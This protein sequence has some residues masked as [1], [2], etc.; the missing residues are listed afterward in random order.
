M[1]KGPFNIGSD[2]SVILDANDVQKSADQFMLERYRAFIPT[3]EVC[4]II[5]SSSAYQNKQLSGPHYVCD[6]FHLKTPVFNSDFSTLTQRTAIA[7][8]LGYSEDDELYNISLAKTASAVS[9]I[10]VELPLPL[11][12][13]STQVKRICTDVLMHC[14]QDAELEKS[15]KYHSECSISAGVLSGNHQQWSGSFINIGD[16]MIVILD[17]D[18]LK[19][20][21]ISPAMVKHRTKGNYSPVSVHEMSKSADILGLQADQIALNENDII[22]YM[23]DGIYSGFDLQVQNSQRTEESWDESFPVMKSIIIT[24]DAFDKA[25]AP[26]KAKEHVSASDVAFALLQEQ[27]RNFLG[28]F[29][30]IKELLQKLQVYTSKNRDLLALT[31]DKLLNF[32]QE[33]DPALKQAL[34]HY[35]HSSGQHDGVTFIP[36]KSL[37]CDLIHVLS[38]QEYG[39]CSTLSV[40]KVPNLK[41][42]LIKSYLDSKNPFVLQTITKLI[43]P[44]ECRTI[45]EG[46]SGD[47]HSTQGL[48]S[49]GV[50]IKNLITCQQFSPASLQELTTTLL[51]AYTGKGHGF[52]DKFTYQLGAALPYFSLAGSS[53]EIL[54]KPSTNNRKDNELKP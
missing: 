39:D 50:L 51:A 44:T 28:E 4:T 12:I 54:P 32:L 49:E 13:D 26:L 9:N 52:W 18:T 33:H 10:F 5:G 22:I 19:P 46:M 14:S 38:T 40:I 29:H 25:L 15:R 43:S 41:K 2:V 11:V 37:I 36:T 16:G 42:E 27:I 1:H 48:P 47:Q 30:E 7:D 34:Q 8:G 31:L 53:S 35:L 45:I 24:D 3:H 6:A 20:K 21:H 23:T 17:K